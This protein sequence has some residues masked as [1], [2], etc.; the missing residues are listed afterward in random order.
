M[1]PLKYCRHRH[2]ER[3]IHYE[4]LCT[5][6]QRHV[7][8]PQ[9]FS[10]SLCILEKRLTQHK[11]DFKEKH[12]HKNFVFHKLATHGEGCEKSQFV[13]FWCLYQS[14][15]TIIIK[16]ICA[17]KGIY[18]FWGPLPFFCSIKQNLALLT[19]LPRKSHCHL[20]G[21]TQ[22]L[23]L[24]NMCANCFIHWG[25]IIYWCHYLNLEWQL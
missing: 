11:S 18:C 2:D 20:F 12:L 25:I 14:V 6:N 15:S 8:H 22:S 1:K 5:L 16:G 7:S 17:I 24:R 23:F 4:D 21:L 9:W 13:A 3:I 10:I 19:C